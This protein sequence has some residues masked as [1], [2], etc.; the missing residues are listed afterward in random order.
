M[1]YDEVRKE[2]RRAFDE[3]FFAALGFTDPDARG[4]AIDDLNDAVCRIVWHRMA[5]TGNS[6]ESRQT[7]DE[8]LAT[9][10]PFGADALDDDLDQND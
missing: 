3:A 5:K 10:Q 7:Y 1:I 9:G 8:W 6:R 2:D 4:R